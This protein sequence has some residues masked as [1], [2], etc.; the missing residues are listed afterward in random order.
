MGKILALPGHAGMT[1]EE[2]EEKHAEKMRRRVQAASKIQAA[3]QIKRQLW[4]AAA[5]EA[6][7]DKA[8]HIADLAHVA[9][10]RTAHVA[11][12]QPYMVVG[13]QFT[14]PYHHSHLGK[15]GVVGS[16][17]LPEGLHYDTCCILGQSIDGFMLG[18]AGSHGVWQIRRVDDVVCKCV[19]VQV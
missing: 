7:Q 3:S 1:V 14:L 15:K 5:E 12:V 17:S 13:R 2:E 9:T 10:V 18:E 8:A 11:F 4:L 16:G 19:C 6:R